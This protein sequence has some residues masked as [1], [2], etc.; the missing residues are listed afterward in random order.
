MVLAILAASLAFSFLQ[1]GGTK[2]LDSSAAGVVLLE[3]T[4][5]ASIHRASGALQSLQQPDIG[6]FNLASPDLN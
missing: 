5:I 3:L 2:A 6:H 1:L 4:P